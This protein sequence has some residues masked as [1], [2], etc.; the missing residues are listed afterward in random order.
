MPFQLS[1]MRSLLR[2]SRSRKRRAM[3]KEGRPHEKNPIRLGAVI[4]CTKLMCEA[5][6]GVS[7]LLRATLVAG[8]CKGSELPFCRAEAERRRDCLWRRL[9]EQDVATWVINFCTL[10]EYRRPSTP[11]TTTGRG[12]VRKC[13]ATLTSASSTE[14]ASKRRR[15]KAL[16]GS[17]ALVDW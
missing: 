14:W 8:V 6:R 7:F 2:D 4:V 3:R 1:A 17:G 12:D 11:T 10:A 9:L 13:F 16:S 5:A 15:A